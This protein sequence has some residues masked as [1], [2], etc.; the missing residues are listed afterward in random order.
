MVTGSSLLFNQED[1][2]DAQ[3]KRRLKTHPD[4]SVPIPSFSPGDIVFCNSEKSKL[5]TRDQ[6]VVRE[7]LPHGMYRLDRLKESGRITR[8]FLPARD[9]FKYDPY[10]VDV[11]E[12]AATP[13]T[14]PSPPRQTVT[15]VPTTPPQRLTPS[16]PPRPATRPVPPAPGMA[17]SYTL[18]V[19][20]YMPLLVP[21]DAFAY[22]DFVPKLAIHT[23]FD[24]EAAGE[25]DSFDTPD[26]SPE[27]T[28]VDEHNSR[29]LR[30]DD[31]VRLARRIHQQRSNTPSPER[32]PRTRPK[33]NTIAPARLVYDHDGQ[34]IVNGRPDDLP[35]TPSI[36]T[37]H[38]EAKKQGWL[39]KRNSK[40]K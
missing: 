32:S 26:E 8:A 12:P 37:K 6:L 33:R 1:I 34:R 13:S 9:L 36:K 25:S 21:F 4:T 11:S 23:E 27:D 19:N 30:R 15:P 22:D 17:S 18:P 39:K 7:E 5:S 16:L 40:E 38:T 3:H 24:T 28:D 20:S 14:Q 10:K 31:P 29:E 35:T 2:I